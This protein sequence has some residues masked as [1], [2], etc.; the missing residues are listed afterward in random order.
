MTG[1]FL[2]GN[3]EWCRTLSATARPART[4]SAF[5]R[6]LAAAWVSAG[7][8][9]PCSMVHDQSRSDSSREE[10]QRAASHERTLRAW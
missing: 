4:P 1:V 5:A 6:K 10:R 9:Q 8:L 3:W 2:G 7:I